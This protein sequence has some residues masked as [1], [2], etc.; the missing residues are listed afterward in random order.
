ME[1][2]EL[3]LSHGDPDPLCAIECDGDDGD[4]ISRGESDGSRAKVVW[5]FDVVYLV[6]EP[7]WEQANKVSFL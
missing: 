2:F 7:F 3:D 1:L 4:V 5:L 6:V